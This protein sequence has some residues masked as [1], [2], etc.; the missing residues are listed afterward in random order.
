MKTLILFLV[1]LMPALADSRTLHLTGTLTN[2]TVEV[3]A[4]AQ[5]EI[6]QDGEKLSAQ[7]VTAAPL[8]G[9]GTLTGRCLDG[10]CELSGTLDGGFIA[11]FRGVLSAREFRGTY[12]VT[13]SPGQTQYGRFSFALAAPTQK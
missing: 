1:L 9:T 3:V 6:T 12:V 10:W 8:S 5:L 13:V 11:K 4:S 2:T 7:L